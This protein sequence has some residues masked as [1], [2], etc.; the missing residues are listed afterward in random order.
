MH[1]TVQRLTSAEVQAFDGMGLKQVGLPRTARKSWK[2]RSEGPALCGR[3]AAIWSHAPMS[4]PCVRAQATKARKCSNKM[5]LSNVMCAGGRVTRL[6]PLRW[7]CIAAE[8]LVFA[9]LLTHG[10]RSARPLNSLNNVDVHKSGAFVPPLAGPQASS[11]WAQSLLNT[12]TNTCTQ[13]ARLALS[14]LSFHG[15]Q[16][17]LRQSYIL[18]PRVAVYMRWLRSLEA[19]SQRPAPAIR[20][21]SHGTACSFKCCP[22]HYPPWASTLN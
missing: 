1:C 8:L 2:H 17:V 5:Q 21:P 22:E 7:R 9:P 16:T 6:C 10:W 19:G 12:G 3:A 4:L 14:Q 15:H 13:L 11:R 20:C 18:R